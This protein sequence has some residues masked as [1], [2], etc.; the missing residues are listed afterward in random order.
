MTNHK[1]I[2][3]AGETI[4]QN[5][6]QTQGCTITQRNY[7]SRFGEIDIIAESDDALLFIEVK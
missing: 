3:N 2:G 1:I 4:A 6:L 7:H 5:Y